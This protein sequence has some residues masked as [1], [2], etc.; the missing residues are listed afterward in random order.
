MVKAL[1]ERFFFWRHPEFQQLVCYPVPADPQALRLEV[2]RL[3]QQG[4][5]ETRTA[6]CLQAYGKNP[7]SS[8]KTHDQLIIGLDCRAS[9]TSCSP[10]R[11]IHTRSER[12]YGCR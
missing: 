7:D 11:A 9:G 4:W 5:T 1:C 3:S 10:R 12:R 2:V 6:E 8:L